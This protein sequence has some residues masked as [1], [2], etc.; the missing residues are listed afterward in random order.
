VEVGAVF[1]IR[2]AAALEGQFVLN[3][4]K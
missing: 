1:G 4:S 3:G 2:V